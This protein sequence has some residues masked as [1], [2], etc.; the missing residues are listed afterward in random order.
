MEYV[1]DDS[2][3]TGNELIDEQHKQLFAAIND[4]LKISDQ[5]EGADLKK[6]L[7]FLNEYTIKHFFDEEQLQQKYQYP[8]YPN[9]KK[10]HEGFKALVRELSHKWIM[11]GTS[12]LLT[13]EVK[14]KIGDWLVSHIKGQDIKL[15][16][17]IKS[18][19]A[20]S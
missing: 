5:G 4:L 15:G 19:K 6:S 2:F 10:L 1:W 14:T 9:H 16:A 20:E 18:V 12:K 17:Y 3:K 8:D 7:D 13:D 11:S